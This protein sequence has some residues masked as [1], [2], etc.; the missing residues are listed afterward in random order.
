MELSFVR[1]AENVKEAGALAGE[2]IQV[3]S[4]VEAIDAVGRYAAECVEL[5]E[6]MNQEVM[7]ETIGL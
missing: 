4:K 3:I 1:T 5:L 2:G 7:A 6:R